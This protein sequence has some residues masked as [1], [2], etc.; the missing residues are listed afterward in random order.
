MLPV[1]DLGEKFVFYVF[2]E[3]KGVGQLGPP[4]SE[5]L[6]INP[7]GPEMFCPTLPLLVG[8][9]KMAHLHISSSSF[10]SATGNL[11]QHHKFEEILT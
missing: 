9:K 2:R 7:K 6:Y 3:K 1:A 8:A 4:F 5:E 10:E 11:N